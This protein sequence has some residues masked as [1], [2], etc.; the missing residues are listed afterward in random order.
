MN[1]REEIE[2]LKKGSAEYDEAIDDVLE[3]LKNMFKRCQIV[4]TKTGLLF[5]GYDGSFPK[6]KNTLS[7]NNAKDYL[8]YG[9]TDSEVLEMAFGGHFT[10]KDGEKCVWNKIVY[11]GSEINKILSE[12]YEN[13][14]YIPLKDFSVKKVIQSET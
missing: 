11:S 5:N 6:G 10:E 8:C 1:Q 7:V 13:S 4:H 2:K 14:N 3:L 12:I 9:K